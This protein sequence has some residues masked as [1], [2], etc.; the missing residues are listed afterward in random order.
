MPFSLTVETDS[1]VISLIM[2]GEGLVAQ[3][4]VEGAREESKLFSKLA[5]GTR[6]PA[7]QHYCERGTFQRSE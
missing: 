4:N 5:R 2:L 7:S 1:E 6:F 3:A